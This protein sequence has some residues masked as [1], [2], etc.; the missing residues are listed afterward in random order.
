MKD[1]PVKMAVEPSK[2]WCCKNILINGTH[3]PESLR[4]V[5][6][7]LREGDV[8]ADIGANYG[9]YSMVGAYKVGSSGKVIAF[10]PQKAIIPIL[11][12]SIALNN[13]DNVTVRNTAIGKDNATLT[14]YQTSA[15]N[16]GQASLA[17]G[18][19]DAPHET[20]SVYP[21]SKILEDENIKS[22][23]GMKI[24]VEG[25]ELQVLQGAKLLFEKQPP[26]FV[27][28]EIEPEHLKR[29]GTS[30]DDIFKFFKKHNYSLY[31]SYHSD[32][33]PFS[34]SEEF[35]EFKN[36]T[37]VLA[38][39]RESGIKPPKKSAV[40]QELESLE[41]FLK[42][43]TENKIKKSANHIFA[44]I[45]TSAEKIGDTDNEVLIS[46]FMAVLEKIKKYL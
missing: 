26:K 39:H 41:K 19:K 35:V 18:D 27:H 7:L 4:M 25:A 6:D 1:F 33:M 42:K 20:V 24:D 45:T 2:S 10:E 16:N 14:L 31:V 9:V 17:W 3:E 32:W 28:I 11:E 40:L 13:F 46:R 5:S 22:V 43:S 44:R 23:A 15:I 38:L 30:T 34:S 37:N 12:Q 36:H 29:F 21:L 8:F